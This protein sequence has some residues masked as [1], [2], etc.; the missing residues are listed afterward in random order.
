MHTEQKL[1]GNAH[2]ASSNRLRRL[3]RRVTLL[4]LRDD[5]DRT[6]LHLACSYCDDVQTIWCLST[7]P[8]VG[9][10]L[11]SGGAQVDALD[12]DKNTPLI[13]AAQ[14][15]VQLCNNWLS[16]LGLDADDAFD[17]QKRSA[18]TLLLLL[19]HGAHVDAH[20]VQ[21][22][23]FL[24]LISMVPVAHQE[25]LLDNAAVP[26]VVSLK[27]LAARRIV[28]SNHDYE[29]LMLPSGVKKLIRRH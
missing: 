1:T 15:C 13:T 18:D 25:G 7:K 22:Q 23:S 17:Q 10:L 14:T 2:A 12:A 5:R 9:L 11:N 26:S 19:D 28:D 6:L 29:R 4:N 27:C 21:R 8:I 3:V 24:D 20:N 16:S